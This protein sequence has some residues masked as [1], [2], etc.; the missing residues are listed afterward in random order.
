MNKQSDV[1]AVKEA[2]Q[3]WLTCL[4]NDDLQGMLDTCDPEVIT[5]NEK[6]P[7]T[8]GI[9]HIRTKYEPRMKA[10]TFNSTFTTEH[11]AIYDSVAIAVGNFS[12]QMV[13]K[14]SGETK[15]GTGRLALAYRRHT[16]GTWKMV[17][18]MDNNA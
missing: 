14:K 3:Q 12:I 5:A 16:N 18:D 10:A 17:F 7:T 13:D 1:D 15:E 9:E 11:L 6:A 2:I 4:D 8:I